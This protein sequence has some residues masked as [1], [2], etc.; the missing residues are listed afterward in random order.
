MIL[1]LPQDKRK[2]RKQ[3]NKRSIDRTNEQ[4]VGWVTNKRMN[5]CRNFN[6]LRRREECS[7]SLCSFHIKLSKD[8]LFLRKEEEEE[9]RQTFDYERTIMMGI[10]VGWKA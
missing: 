3:T 10:E 8:F 7:K 2:S 4:I 9:R 1:I 6:C 5:M